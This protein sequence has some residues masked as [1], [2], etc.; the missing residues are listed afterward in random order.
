M[1]MMPGYTSPGFCGTEERFTHGKVY[2]LLGVC[3]GGG[4]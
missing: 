2:C 1:E 3:E 4:R